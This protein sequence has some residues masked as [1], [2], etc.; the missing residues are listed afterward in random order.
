[1]STHDIAAL[2][3]EADHVTVLDEGRVVHTGTTESFF[4]HTPPDTPPDTAPARAA[5]GACTALLNRG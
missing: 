3:E 2:A 5:D 1:M 4:R